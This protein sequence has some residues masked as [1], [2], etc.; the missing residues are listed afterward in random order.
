MGNV[1]DSVFSRLSDLQSPALVRLLEV[2]DVKDTR[3]SSLFQ[4]NFVF[5]LTN[6]SG[7]LHGY[8]R[9]IFLLDLP[10]PA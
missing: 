10:D 5:Q 1:R 4:S 7:I 3:V 9:L 2:L 6:S 8:L